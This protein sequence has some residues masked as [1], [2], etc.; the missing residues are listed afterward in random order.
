MRLAVARVVM[1]DRFQEVAESIAADQTA[2]LRE[3]RKLRR[4]GPDQGFQ[5]ETVDAEIQQIQAQL[6]WVS[7]V[8]EKHDE[9]LRRPAA[10]RLAAVTRRYA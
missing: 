5:P 3:L 10:K 7:A 8:R 2:E 1:P 4:E 6:R 9:I